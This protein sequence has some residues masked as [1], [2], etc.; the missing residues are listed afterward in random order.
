MDRDIDPDWWNQHIRIIEKGAHPNF[1][2]SKFSDIGG[3]TLQVP[4]KGGRELYYPDYPPFVF[5]LKGCQHGFHK[6]KPWIGGST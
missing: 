6:S 2:L 1:Y 4:L 3:F 5:T